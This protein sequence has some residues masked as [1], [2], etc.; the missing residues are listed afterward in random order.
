MKILMNGFLLLLFLMFGAFS[1]ST[2]TKWY[3]TPNWF[4]A[5]LGLL[6]MGVYFYF[7]WRYSKEP[8]AVKLCPS[9]RKRLEAQKRASDTQTVG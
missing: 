9:C 1:L 5:I 2:L 3:E 8:S 7:L 6:M 4:D